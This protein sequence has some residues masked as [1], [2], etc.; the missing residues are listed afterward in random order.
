MQTRKSFLV[1]LTSIGALSLLF[2]KLSSFLR[3]ESNQ[4]SASNLSLKVKKASNIIP[5]N[6]V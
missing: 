2:P 6:S 3:P 4:D 1:K 5:R